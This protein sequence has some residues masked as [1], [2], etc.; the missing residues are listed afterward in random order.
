MSSA[1]S[2][3]IAG[4]FWYSVG[5]NYHVFPDL[6]LKTKFRTYNIARRNVWVGRI[7]LLAYFIVVGVRCQRVPYSKISYFMLRCGHSSS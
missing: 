3:G 7:V 1:S 4:N 5:L 2:D 6:N